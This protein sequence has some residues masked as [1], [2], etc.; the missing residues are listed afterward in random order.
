M[1]LNQIRNETNMLLFKENFNQQDWN[2]VYVSNDV[3][4]ALDSFS[5]WAL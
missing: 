4:E 3:H 5:T 2:N 1:N